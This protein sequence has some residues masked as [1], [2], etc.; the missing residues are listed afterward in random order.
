[1]KPTREKALFALAPPPIETSFSKNRRPRRV[2]AVG[3]RP[4]AATPASATNASSAKP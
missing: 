2:Q 3:A 4:T 1:M